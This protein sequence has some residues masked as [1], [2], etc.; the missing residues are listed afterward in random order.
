MAQ[1]ARRRNSEP[2]K[3]PDWVPDELLERLGLLLREDGFPKQ[4]RK[5]GRLWTHRLD[6]LLDHAGGLVPPA[7]LLEPIEE[8]EERYGLPRV[9]LTMLRVGLPS[10]LSSG[11]IDRFLANDGLPPLPVDADTNG[12]APAARPAPAASPETLLERDRIAEDLRRERERTRD[13]DRKLR[14]EREAHAATRSELTSERDKLRNALREMEKQLA[15]GPSSEAITAAL[16]ARN[17][18]EDAAEEARR[19]T[20]EAESRATSAEA[21]ARRADA[22]L[23]AA[24][25][26]VDAARAEA[27]RLRAAPPSTTDLVRA[28]RHVGAA[29]LLRLESPAPG[30]AACSR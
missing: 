1:R 28:A 24:R 16:E 29:A 6:V 21:A 5:V 3:A 4:A 30:D 2:R 20:R 11:V 14:E 7:E 19:A 17:E 13:K 26:D 25:S 10:P 22:A 23:E 27:E 12:D 18:D 8:L 9:A 15:S